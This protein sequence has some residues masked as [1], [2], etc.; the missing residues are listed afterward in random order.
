MWKRLVV[1]IGIGSVLGAAVILVTCKQQ[2]P[3]NNNGDQSKG[4]TLAPA[5]VVASPAHDEK[6]ADKGAS[7]AD[8]VPC[9]QKLLAW[10]EGITVWAVLLTMLVIGWQ[11]WETSISARAALK[12]TGHMQ[13]S[14]RAWLSISSANKKESILRPGAPPMYLWKIRN[15]GKTPARLIETQAVCQITESVKLPPDPVFP[16]SVP[17]GGRILGPDESLDFHAFWTDERG[18]LFRE[19]VE[20]LDPVW[21]TAYGFVKYMTVFDTEVRES[22][23]CDDFIDGSNTPV[24]GDNPARI[25][26]RP[27]LDAPAAYTKST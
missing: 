2:T 22:R 23:F 8:C 13:T 21:L 26:F 7:S 17:L 15:V 16:K 20:T 9:R 4:G 12:Q 27:Y 6:S 1:L 3:C 10:P 25:I 24:Q 19:A 18:I 14:E 5:V 11:S